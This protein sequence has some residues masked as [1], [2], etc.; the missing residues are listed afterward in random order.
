MKTTMASSLWDAELDTDVCNPSTNANLTLTMRLAFHAV[1]PENGADEGVYQV[2]EEGEEAEER[3]IR[4]WTPSAW[5]RWTHNL[6][7]SAERF[8][9]GKFWL[10]NNFDVLEFASFGSRYR[11]NIHCRLRIQIVPLEQSHSLI[12]GVRLHPS[13]WNFRP[14]SDR[15][16]DRDQEMALALFDADNKPVFQRAHIHE[17]GH[18]LGLQ[19]IDVGKAHCPVGSDTRR[20]ACYGKVP[21]DERTVMGGGMSLVP[22]FA[23]P[24]QKAIIKLTGQG[25][26]MYSGDWEPRMTRIAPQRLLHPRA[27]R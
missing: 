6:V 20:R 16:T 7:R 23:L 11:A 25:V 10:F 21:A 4:R 12:F 18:L 9:T 17:V 24:W 13:A 19:H 27:P 5:Q 22:F 15:M 2:F 8:W 14:Q 26:P 3:K 1:N